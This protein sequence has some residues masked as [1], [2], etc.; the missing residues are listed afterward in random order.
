MVDKLIIERLIVRLKG[1]L[2]ELENATDID[3]EKYSTDARTRRFVERL[4]HLSLETCLD[5][6]HH[7]ISEEGYRE[8][9]SYRD[10]FSVLIEEGIL[11]GEEGPVYEKMAAFRNLLVHHYEK[12]DDAAVFGIFKKH[13]N[14]FHRFIG[15]ILKKI[16]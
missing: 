8:P 6:G 14:D 9:E 7:I 10:V 16:G 13:L 3:W 4:L 1:Y 12:I 11:P 15:H 5:I 2:K